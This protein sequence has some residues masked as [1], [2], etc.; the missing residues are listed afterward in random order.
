MR[1]LGR[2]CGH[3]KMMLKNMVT[4][5]F[6]HGRI[7]TTETRQ[8]SM[9]HSGKNDYLWPKKMTLHLEGWY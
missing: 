1:R 4:S 2:T 8:K 6:M 9:F 7:V 3:R 5:L